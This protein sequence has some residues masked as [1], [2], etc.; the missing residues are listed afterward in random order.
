M[1]HVPSR[2]ALHARDAL[3]FDLVNF[4]SHNNDKK[5]WTGTFVLQSIITWRVVLIL[6]YSV[7]QI[8]KLSTHALSLHT[9]QKACA[10]N[11][12]YLQIAMNNTNGV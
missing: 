7:R 3:E 4:N 2:W 11:N 10:S 12:P 8:S 1:I 5:H 9:M 6:P